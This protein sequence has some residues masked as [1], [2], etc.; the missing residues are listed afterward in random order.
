[1]NG[2]VMA[3][4]PIFIHLILMPPLINRKQNI[5]YSDVYV[6]IRTIGTHDLHS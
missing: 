4:Q 5:S 1:M 3:M 6:T 2:L